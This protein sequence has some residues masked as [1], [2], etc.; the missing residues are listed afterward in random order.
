MLRFVRVWVFVAISGL[1]AFVAFG[2]CGAKDSQLDDEGDPG[3]GGSTASL[4]QGG[5]TASFG[6]G[7]GMNVGGGCVGV[8]S[9]AEKVPLDMYIMLDQSGSMTDPPTGGSGTKWSAVTSAIGAFVNQGQSAGIGV[10]IQY[11]PLPSGVTCP[12]VPVQC[13]SDLDCSPGC[14]PCVQPFPTFPG[15]CTGVGAADSCQAADYATPDVPIA[16]LPGNASAIVQSMA[17]HSPVGGTPTSAALQGAVDQATS[18]ATAHPGHVVIAVL[19][20]DGDPTSCDSNLS[21]INAIAAAGASGSPQVLTFV[22]G[23][24]GSV[25]AL[26]G[27]AAAGGTSQAYMIDTNPN[28]QQ[29]FLDALNDIQG[30][31]LP[32][33]YLI[34]DPP[35]GE[36]ID[37]G[38][39]NVSLSPGGG[40]T[41]TIPQVSGPGACLPGEKAW[42]Y[43]DPANPTQIVLCPDTCALVSAD[44]GASIDV[45]LNCATIVR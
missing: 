32:C 4:G 2:G 14:G 20:T 33:S 29:A 28:V 10:G 24:G 21:A 45:V 44:E 41:E 13:S 42:Y 19:A 43:D 8:G 39:V 22:I 7:G 15:F 11:F 12:S 6:Q 9:T 31:A 5:S 25:S 18:W 16:L 17:G 36:S 3:T 30:Q 40:A 1:G 37:F 34:P 35:P 27:I 26:N 38:A 23:V